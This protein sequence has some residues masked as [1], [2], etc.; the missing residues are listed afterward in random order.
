MV[1]LLYL[2]VGASGS[3]LNIDFTPLY[4][5][6]FD[7]M[8][9]AYQIARKWNISDH[10]KRVKDG[11]LTYDYFRI[12]GGKIEYCISKC[13]YVEMFETY[14]IR[15]LCKIFCMTDT[16]SYENLTRHVI[17]IRHSDLSDGNCCHDEIIDKGMKRK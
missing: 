4:G 16:T 3:F 10:D 11:S 17:F 8:P 1:I 14:G 15:S 6:Y 13:V 5:R 7:M 12:S 9:N 2:K